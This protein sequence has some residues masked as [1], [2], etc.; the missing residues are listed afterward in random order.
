MSLSPEEKEILV[1][2]IKYYYDLRSFKLYKYGKIERGY[3]GPEIRIHDPI[4]LRL[5]IYGS[6]TLI[7]NQET[8]FFKYSREFDIHEYIRVGTKTICIDIKRYIL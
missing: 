1:D 4:A 2:K 7:Y 6:R 3:R 5:R 8:S